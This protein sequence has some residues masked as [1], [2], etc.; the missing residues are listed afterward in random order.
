MN[1]E[2]RYISHGMNFS[3]FF[4]LRTS[5]QRIQLINRYDYKQPKAIATEKKKKKKN[6]AKKS[7]R[8]ENTHRERI[9]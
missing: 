4:C 8:N 1:A 7:K 9:N 6:C 3:F 2:G 5:S